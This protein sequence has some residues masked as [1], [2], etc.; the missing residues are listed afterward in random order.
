MRTSLD[1]VW[2]EL[3]GQVIMARMRGQVTQDMLKERHE[4]ILHISRDTGCTKLLLDDLEMDAMSYEEI[5]AQRALNVELNE[6]H[7][8]IAVVVPNSRMAYLARLQFGADNH[9]VFYTDMAAALLW[10]RNGG[11]LA[12]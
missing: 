10:L 11:T 9:Q 3:V 2:V 7:L 8:Q 6:K 12:R 5:E 4:Q 1:K